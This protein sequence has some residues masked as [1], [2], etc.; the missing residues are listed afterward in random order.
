MIRLLLLLFFVYL[1]VCLLILF[2]FLFVSSL[3]NI[4][5]GLRSWSVRPYL[6]P[7]EYAFICFHLGKDKI[8]PFKGCHF[9]LFKVGEH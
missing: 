5:H 4:K 3:L 8:P 1:F 6:R 2:H 9:F 7:V